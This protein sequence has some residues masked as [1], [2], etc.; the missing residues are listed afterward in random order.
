MTQ[1]YS[2]AVSKKYIRYD[3]EFND[4]DSKCVDKNSNNITNLNPH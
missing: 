2:F 3:Y 4:N 1:T